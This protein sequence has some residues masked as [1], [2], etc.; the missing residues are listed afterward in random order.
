MRLFKDRDRYVTGEFRFR[1]GYGKGNPRKMVQTWAE[2]EMRNLSRMFQVGILCPEPFLL[3][4][5]VL[6]MNFLGE[7]F[8]RFFFVFS[9]FFFF[10][11]L[12]FF[13]LSFFFLSLFLFFSLFSFFLSCIVPSFFL[14]SFV[15][16]C[17]LCLSLVSFIVFIFLCSFILFLIFLFSPPSLSSPSF[18][19]IHPYQTIS[20]SSYL[21]QALT[22][23]QLLY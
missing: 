20:I 19:R 23:G 2:K 10:S 3:R 5:H 14:S 15:L 21:S 17:L 9:S 8:L 12:F 4:G 16:F 7:K 18:R 6:L 11:L 1:H 22:V 13:F